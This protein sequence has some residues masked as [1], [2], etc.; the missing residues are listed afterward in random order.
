MS[1]PSKTI[2]LLKTI[3]VLHV[4]VLPV[5]QVERYIVGM[6]VAV[7]FAVLIVFALVIDQVHSK[8]NVIRKASF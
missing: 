2:H 4:L 7:F 5:M 3:M 6:K 8:Q 1:N